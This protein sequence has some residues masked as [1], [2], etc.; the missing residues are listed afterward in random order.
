VE[1]KK[2]NQ[3]FKRKKNKR[4]QETTDA[5]LFHTEDIQ[6]EFSPSLEKNKEELEGLF[7]GTFDFEMDEIQVGNKNGFICYL[8][9]ML[10]KG[11]LTEKILE[12]IYNCNHDHQ[13]IT[14]D[15]SFEKIRESYFPSLP[16]DY[17]HTLHQVVWHILNGYAVILIKGLNKA[18][19]L[20][21]G[22]IEKRSVEEPSTQTIIRGP[23]EGFIENMNTNISLVRRRIRNPSLKFERYQIGKDSRTDVAIAY[24]DN[25]TNLDVLDEVRRRIEKI[26]VGAILDS[27]NIEEFI[28]DETYTP[29]PL[30]F[31]TERSDTIASH[32]LDGKIAI[33]VD[34][35]PFVL[36]LPCVFS[37]FFQSSEDYYQPFFMASFVRFIRYISFMIALTLPSLYVAISSFHHELLPTQLL[38]SVQAQREGVPFPA[39]IEI[40]LMELSFEVLREA[41]VRMPRAVGQTV[42]IVG[43]LVIGQAAVEAGIVSNV[44]VI[45]V[46]FTAIASFVS[47]I[48]NF[49]I[50]TRLLRFLLIF[51]ASAMGLYGVL[52]GLIVMVIHLVSLRSFGISY[53]T[54]VAPLQ[55][56]DQQDVFV[57]MPIW[58]NK[59]RPSYLMTKAP[60]KKTSNQ[61]PSPPNTG[62]GS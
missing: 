7:H 38:I 43:A 41:G 14:D 55:I 11:Q 42:S 40:L 48:Y 25:I 27:G 1:L 30:I 5:Q 36:T 57:R 23:K 60:V 15:K 52:V 13:V 2:W 61:A 19:S 8:S 58:K 26:D 47:P 28:T 21:I 20:E 49:A 17:A 56:E 10:D 9:T 50:S 35:T 45:I 22:N 39:V 33:F 31:N 53:L 12:P 51:A 24:M 44:L 3:L 62:G 29:F 59:R 32:L 18:F 37:D 4:N 54:P 6:V 46:A 34:G 16:Y